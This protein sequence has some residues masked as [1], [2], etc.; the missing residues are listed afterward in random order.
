MI[1]QKAA[2]AGKPS[3]Y[4]EVGPPLAK[5]AIEAVRKGPHAAQVLTEGGKVVVGR[6]FKNHH[7]V[8]KFSHLAPNIHDAEATFLEP[9]AGWIVDVARDRAKGPHVR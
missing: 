5:S 9:L 3:F 8:D 2:V 7:L 6:L 1:L 4:L